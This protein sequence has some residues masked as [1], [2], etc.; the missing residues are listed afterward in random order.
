MS[1]TNDTL[2]IPKGE[3]F[4]GDPC[5]CFEGDWGDILDKTDFFSEEVLH[6]GKLLAAFGTKYGDG[7]YLDQFDNKFPVDA[8]L[9]G[10]VPVCMITKEGGKKNNWLK[11]AGLFVK[12]Q[13]GEKMSEFDGTITI[14]EHIIKTGDDDFYDN[15]EEECECCGRPY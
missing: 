10:I 11:Q 9:I 6:K 1:R 2:T 3:Y 8:G 13:C 7:T 4:I 5:Y 12:F 14:G 15:D